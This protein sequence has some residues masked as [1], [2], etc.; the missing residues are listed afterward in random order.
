MAFYKVPQNVESEDKLLGPLSFKQFI[1]AI[2]A[3]VMCAAVFFGFKLNPLIGF[4]FIF[5]AFMFLVLAFYQRP[6]QPVESYLVALFGYWFKPRARTWNRDGISEHVLITAPKKIADHFSDGRSRE[7]VKSQ[8]N[9]LADVVDTRGWST[10]GLDLNQVQAQNDDRLVGLD[11]ISH[12]NPQNAAQA[13]LD[14]TEDIQDLASSQVAQN[15]EAMAPR[16]A[17][18]NQNQNTQPLQALSPAEARRQQ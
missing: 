5:P 3:A 17:T 14:A 13:A 10:R 12:N 4:L 16:A 9:Q 8:L 18:D 7:Q 2:V 1:Y 15:F 6:D 11:E